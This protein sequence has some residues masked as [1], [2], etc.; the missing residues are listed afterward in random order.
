MKHNTD[1]LRSQAEHRP[2]A[3]A[4]KT[5]QRQLNFHE[6]SG[7][8][9]GLASKLTGAGIDHDMHVG[10]LVQNS[11]QALLMIYALLR[12]GAVIVPLHSRLTIE[13]ISAQLRFADCNWVLTDDSNQTHEIRNGSV[14]SLSFSEILQLEQTAGIPG[15]EIQA[16]RTAVIMF[17]SGSSGKPKAV[18]LTLSN[19]LYSAIGSM[20][21]L[22]IEPDDSWLLSLPVYHIGGFSI[23]TRSLVYGTPV[24]IPDSLETNDLVDAIRLFDPSHIS[25]VPTMLHRIIETGAPPNPS[26]RII[27]L[28]GGP[29]D[30]SLYTISRSKGWKIIPTYGATE[31]C[32]QSATAD[33]DDPPEYPVALPLAFSELSVVDDNGVSVPS[34][35]TGQI[36]VKGAIVAKG[37]YKRND[38]NA[39][40]LHNGLFRTGDYGYFDEKGRLSVVS[41]RTD[42]IISGGENINPV[43]IEDVL[44]QFT[45]IRDACVFPEENKEWGQ[46]VVAAIVL[47][48][49]Y[50]DDREKFLNT[51]RKYLEE[52]IS[53]F[54]VPKKLFYVD[55]LPYTEAGKLNREMVKELFRSRP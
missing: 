55:S 8:V 44:K 26:Q 21:R 24:L 43:E 37:Y 49:R 5:T 6:L 17:T 18:E 51:V 9:D 7:E 46:L 47:D 50:Q 45:E 11:V 29:I 22:G 27:L 28:G 10:L 38:Q 53:G 42:L 41:R 33:P 1:W 35:K 16:N 30:K 25:L 15:I 20:L 23:V 13:E 12:I 54:K 31:T 2:N 40:V 3:I 39:S 34:K 32:S 14:P 36:I 48:K 4:L 19:F 52:K